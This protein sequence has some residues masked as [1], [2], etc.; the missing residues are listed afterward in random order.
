MP[1]TW[2]DLLRPETSHADD[3]S[4][5]PP[6][7]PTQPTESASTDSASDSS[8]TAAALPGGAAAESSTPP[9]SENPPARPRGPH[10]QR[11]RKDKPPKN[12]HFQNH[13]SNLP[14]NITAYPPAPPAAAVPPQPQMLVP[15]PSGNGTLV[16]MAEYRALTV[17]MLCRQLE[18][19]FSVDNLARD[20]YL[21]TLMDPDGFVPLSSLS[22]FN[23]VQVMLLDAGVL[24][25]ACFFSAFLELSYDLSA[26]RKASDWSR[27]TLTSV[28]PDQ[29]PKN[30][31][32]K[33]IRSRIE[34]WALRNANEL[35][36]ETK[37]T[38]SG[39]LMPP[40]SKSPLPAH[41][42]QRVPDAH[43]HQLIV[44][45]PSDTELDSDDPLARGSSTEVSW[46][47]DHL[48]SDCHHDANCTAVPHNRFGHGNS[49]FSDAAPS[50]GAAD[51]N[52]HCRVNGMVGHTGHQHASAPTSADDS[53]ALRLIESKL[54]KH[55]KSVKQT[56]RNYAS[57][58]LLEEHGFTHERYDRFVERCTSE[59]AR[60]DAGNSQ[61]MRVLYTFWKLFLRRSGHWNDSMFNSFKHCALDDMQRHQNH[62]GIKQLASCL[63]CALLERGFTEMLYS[64]LEDVALKD[65]NSGCTCC[66]EELVRFHSNH[67]LAVD[68]P[69]DSQLAELSRNWGISEVPQQPQHTLPHVPL[70]L[71]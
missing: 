52:G 62:N 15:H 18:F 9:P 36:P 33:R 58:A 23:R 10:P 26:V 41:Q 5:A 39:V 16:T 49:A 71:P 65:A 38:K 60:E 19:Y 31:A 51:T 24:L 69:M 20:L 48:E 34:D 8:S 63:A 55:C 45:S 4:P 6:K 21:R 67:G 50:S 66:I 68:I 25:D 12:N 61:A 7:A 13:S 11:Q 59:R 14:P 28:A 40:P 53:D 1:G 70:L 47:F 32:A 30:G 35:R 46:F 29:L 22:Q 27:W 2:A 54:N 42:D 17:D 44:V 64:E 56:Q 43:L 57:K 37:M 3:S